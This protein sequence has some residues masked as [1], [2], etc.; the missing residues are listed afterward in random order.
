MKKLLRTPYFTQKSGTR[1]YS[2]NTNNVDNDGPSETARICRPLCHQAAVAV[3][4]GSPMYQ[5]ENRCCII[6]IL[7]GRDL[8]LQWIR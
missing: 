1:Q 2:S 4:K 7:E 3:F 8:F 5:V 6:I